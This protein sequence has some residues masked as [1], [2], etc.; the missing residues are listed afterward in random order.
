MTELSGGNG[1]SVGERGT[2]TP[3][4]SFTRSGPDERGDLLK[5]PP[6][7]S[8]KVTFVRVV[9]VAALIPLGAFYFVPR[10]YNLTAMPYR[11]DQALAS[12]DNYNPAL[13]ELVVHERVTLSAFMALDKMEAALASVQVTDAA[14][15]A[16]LRTLTKQIEVDLHATLALAGSRTDDLVASLDVLTA[17]LKL[18]QPPI[19]GATAALVGNTAAMDAIVS[20]A[21]STADNV[22]SARVSA[23]ESANDLSGK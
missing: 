1:H 17:Q 18:L 22:H 21:R 20:D 8:R 12:A 4:D 16:E 15:D 9:I 2:G 13:S 6:R 19:D 23:E 5:R 11:L 7:A 10:L 14:V 3:T